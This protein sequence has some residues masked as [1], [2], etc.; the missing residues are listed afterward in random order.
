MTVT[1]VL[2]LLLFPFIG[3]IINGFFGSR[4][5]KITGVIGTLAI[6]ASWLIAIFAIFLPVVGGAQLDQDLYEWIRSGTLS[7]SIGFHIDALAAVM[8]LVVTTVSLFIHIYSIGYMRD[9]P[10]FFRFFTYLNLFVFAMLILVTANNYLMM[11][12][13][14]EGVGLC[15]YLLIGFWYERKSAIDAGKKAFIVNRIGDFGFLLGLFTIFAAFGTFRFE[16]IFADAAMQSSGVLVAITL[17]LFVGAIGKSAQIPLYVW[18]PDAMEGPTPVSSLIHAA[19]MV[20]AGV[21]MIARSAPLFDLA[22]VG[23]VVA[24]V[25]ILTAFFAATMA[26]VNNDLKR[27]LAYSTVSQ[28]GYMFAGVGVGAYAAGIFHLMTHAFFKGLMFL[29]AG[30][31]MH[32]MDDEL[33]MRKM[34]GLRSK[35]PITFW[36][37]LV[38]AIAIAGIPPFSGFWSKDEIL[39]S[40]FQQQHL[41]WAIGLVT[42][43][44]TAFYMFRLIFMTFFGEPRYEE[45]V[46]P[47]ESPPVMTI[48]LILLA[49]PAALIGLVGIGGHNGWFARLLASH[50]DRGVEVATESVS[51]LALMIPSV[52][53]ALF[54]IVLAY[55]IYGAHKLP[56]LKLMAP[57][58]GLKKLLVNRYYVDE[59]YDASIIQPIQFISK[60]VLWKVVDVGIIDGM[61][62]LIGWLV[63]GIGSLLRLFQTGRVQA[64]A[65]SVIIGITVILGYYLLLR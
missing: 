60:Y 46:H 25:G 63:R 7:V 15:S 23:L 21:Y 58:T 34:G 5:G 4:L 11:F 38:G 56:I 18:L 61:V 55:A 19:T 44:L 17:L 51:A 33:D 10:G 50:G 49:I 27:V 53:V 65:L 30:S 13:G 45:S 42:A 36:T 12:V 48:P 40:A 9:D 16:E 28:L 47:H 3:V 52:L 32:G 24:W 64:Y 59:I 8:I 57:P 20:T 6:A 37:F 62:N 54:G 14:W 43:G 39:Y 41:I 35:M 29:T 31:V 1:P 2:L 26:L 22:H